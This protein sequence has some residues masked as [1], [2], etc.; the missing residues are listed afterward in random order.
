VRSGGEEFQIIAPHTSAT[1]ALKVAEKIRLAIAA[2][3]IPGCD[4]VTVSL[5]VGQSME[6]ET[7]DSLA[8]RVDAALARAKRAGRNRV[9]LA[10]E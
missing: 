1:D 2:T 6:E 4:Q 8:V 3:A 7:P 9:E 10:R 5:G